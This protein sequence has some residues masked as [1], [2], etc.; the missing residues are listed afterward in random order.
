M[1]CIKILMVFPTKIG[2]NCQNGTFELLESHNW[3]VPWVIEVVE[4]IPAFEIAIP[5][6]QIAISVISPSLDSNKNRQ[7]KCKL[8]RV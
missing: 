7:R 3:G 6:T 1:I 4:S 5:I 2:G 8:S